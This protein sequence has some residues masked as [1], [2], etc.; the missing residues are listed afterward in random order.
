MEL[1]FISGPICNVEASLRSIITKMFI[2]KE[3]APVE[4]PEHYFDSPEVG[5]PIDKPDYTEAIKELGPPMAEAPYV[6]KHWISR[7][8]YNFGM[9]GS[10]HNNR[11]EI[12][13]S[14]LSK[15][16]GTL[17]GFDSWRT[18]GTTPDKFLSVF[19][20]KVDAPPI[21]KHDYA[22]KLQR[23]YNGMAHAFKKKGFK[24]RELDWSEVILQANK[25]GASTYQDSSNIR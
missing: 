8:L 20:A 24:Y 5:R 2:E 11:V 10:T 15:A 17:H 18:T 19:N 4:Q 22:K 9:Q 13:M 25:Q 23:I 6:F 14:V 21:E 3:N 16:T 7:G 12:A 1:Y